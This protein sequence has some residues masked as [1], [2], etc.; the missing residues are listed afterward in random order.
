MVPFNSVH[1]QDFYTSH[2]K[3]PPILKT[4]ADSTKSLNLW[5]WPSDT[6][7]SAFLWLSRALFHRI[8]VH[9]KSRRKGKK[10][11]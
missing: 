2:L 8:H 10:G 4:G 6:R 1:L 7:L 3:V 5:A 11:S 9:G